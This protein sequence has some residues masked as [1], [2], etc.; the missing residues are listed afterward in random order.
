MKNFGFVT[1]AAGA[2]AAALVRLAGPAAAAP[3]ANPVQVA[4]QGTAIGCTGATLAHKLRVQLLWPPS[5]VPP[6]CI[7]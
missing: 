5:N 4:E 3:V 2:F 6:V 1:I 7:R